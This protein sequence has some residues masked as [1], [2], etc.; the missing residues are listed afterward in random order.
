MLLLFRFKCVCDIDIDIFAASSDVSRRM[1]GGLISISTPETVGTIFYTLA[2]L[3]P[4][5][6]VVEYGLVLGQTSKN[7]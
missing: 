5:S 7:A 3:K 6:A 2:N 4:I 1:L